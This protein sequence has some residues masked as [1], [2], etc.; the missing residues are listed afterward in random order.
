MDAELQKIIERRARK[1]IEERIEAQA[2]ALADKIMSN[3]SAMPVV[4]QPL[5]IEA[6]P[7]IVAEPVV[8][9]KEPRKKYRRKRFHPIKYP[10][11][12]SVKLGR[13]DE[14][15]FSVWSKQYKAIMTA[16]EYLSDGKS[17]TRKEITQVVWQEIGGPY[18]AVSIYIS[19]MLRE[20]F[21]VPVDGEKKA[22]F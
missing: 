18:D 7:V 5:P 22:G 2:Q 21:L 9:T 19:M 6:A 20:Q 4:Q 8:V 3:G 11:Y 15:S 12:I 10:T 1:I 17:C 14:P 13:T 16:R